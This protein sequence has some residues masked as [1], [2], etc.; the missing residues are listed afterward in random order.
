MTKKN[1]LDHYFQKNYE[2]YLTI[3]KKITNHRT[4]HMDIEAEEVYTVIYFNILKRLDKIDLEFFE[5][6]NKFRSVFIQTT[7]QQINWSVSDIQNYKDNINLKFNEINDDE[8]DVLISD[9]KVNNEKITNENEDVKDDYE[10]K[11]NFIFN[12]YPQMFNNGLDRAEYDIIITGKNLTNTKIKQITGCNLTI[13]AKIL[14]NFKNKIRFI[15]KNYDFIK[16]KITLNI[17]S[18][19]HPSIQDK[20]INIIYKI[21]RNDTEIIIINGFKSIKDQNSNYKKGLSI[22]KGGYSHINYNLGFKIDNLTPEILVEFLKNDF[23][24]DIE[25]NIHYDIDINELIKKY[26]NKEFITGT[27]FLIL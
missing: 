9:R 20:L 12:L 7:K 19:L 2:D 16:N 14:K 17:I 18:E 24:I 6:S 1:Y 21:E 25:G 3:I 11:Y 15:Y 4:K 23:D 8:C 27:K 13:S 10:E 26:K 22:L 5:D